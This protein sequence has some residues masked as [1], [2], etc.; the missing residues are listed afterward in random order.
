[1]ATRKDAV[2]EQLNQL[3]GDL[4]GL[5]KAATRDP[6]VEQR[7]QRIWAIFVGVLGA[8]A[9]AASRRAL[10]RLWPILT[11]EKPPLAKTSGASPTGQAGAGTKR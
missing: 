1:V 4:H 11:G 2:M 6:A 10:A 7:K 9:S 3:G 5:W 8:A